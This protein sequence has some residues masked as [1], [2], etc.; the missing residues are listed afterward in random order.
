M[1]T[2]MGGYEARPPEERAR[3]DASDQEARAASDAPGRASQSKLAPEPAQAARGGMAPPGMLSPG[4]LGTWP[5]MGLPPPDGSGPRDALAA[6]GAAGEADAPGA[7]DAPA[8]TLIAPGAAP[9]AD[10]TGAS[11][12]MAGAVLDAQGLG[13]SARSLER[14]PAMWGLATIA[15][16]ALLVAVAIGL[17]LHAWQLAAERD[18]LAEELAKPRPEDPELA[19]AREKAKRLQQELDT[20]NRLVAELRLAAPPDSSLAECT[21][22]LSQLRAVLGSTELRVNNLEL[23][24]RTVQT[25]LA[26]TAKSATD[27]EAKHAEE[28]TRLEAE[29]TAL[30]RK[31]AE[32][33][34]DL[35]KQDRLVKSLCDELRAIHPRKTSPLC[36]GVK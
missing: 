10:A 8:G 14:A 20:S 2:V 21:R 33:G 30:Q 9:A 25:Q 26:S 15:M 13:E 4:A 11:L 29:R 7:P 3:D 31:N 24:L 23:T 1:K 12:T 32:L 6:L 34:H 35:S 18:H 17:G 19:A 28:R 16:P 5:G 36:Q 27:L 22:S